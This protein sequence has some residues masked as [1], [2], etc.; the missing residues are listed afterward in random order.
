[1]LRKGIMAGAS[2]SDVRFARARFPGAL[3]IGVSWMAVLL[4]PSAP[5]ALLR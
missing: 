3:R 5:F 1:M 4:R 2:A